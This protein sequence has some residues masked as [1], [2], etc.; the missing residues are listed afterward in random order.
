MALR[1]TSAWE[2]PSD[3]ASR[4]SL[5]RSA[6]LKYTLVFV[7]TSV[8]YHVGHSADGAYAGKNRAS[9]RRADSGESL[10]WTRFSVISIP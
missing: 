6:S 5:A 3:R 8:G 7:T 9:S 1:M 10:P 4:A 2:I